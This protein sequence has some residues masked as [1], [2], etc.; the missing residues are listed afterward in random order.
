MEKKR[1]SGENKNTVGGYHLLMNAVKENYFAKMKRV[2][3]QWASDDFFVPTFVMN[4]GSSDQILS[5][6]T[7]ESIGSDAFIADRDSTSLKPDLLI[8]SGMV[9]YKSLELIKAEYN[10]LVGRKYVVL[11]GSSKSKMYK[12][13]SYNLVE[14]LE[15]H[16]PID[17][18]VPGINPS[19]EEIIKGLNKLKDIRK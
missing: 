4:S 15:E 8:I 3:S 17:I 5:H 18:T 13:N 16:I 1:D 10:N 2:I 14:N 12:L 9:N 19:R 6:L 7:V 11:I